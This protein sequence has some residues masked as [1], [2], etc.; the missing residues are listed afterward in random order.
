MGQLL[1]M[2]QRADDEDWLERVP[3]VNATTR[4][5]VMPLAE[6]RKAILDEIGPIEAVY[7]AMHPDEP[8]EAETDAKLRDLHAQ[9]EA[10]EDKMA[11]VTA[12]SVAGLIEQL[13]AL[14]VH[15]AVDTPEREPL[16]DAV[17]RGLRAL[18]K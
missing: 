6:R 16:V 18:V 12:T 17:L 7:A 11:A 5:P 15:I 9:V 8:A 10:V 2:P 1:E 14:K 4:D 13:A 3:R